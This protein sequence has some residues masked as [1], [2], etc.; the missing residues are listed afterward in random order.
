M[1]GVSVNATA[2]TSPAA[3]EISRPERRP[4]DRHMA[5]RTDPTSF[6]CA[7]RIVRLYQLQGLI[8]INAILPIIDL[9]IADIQFSQ[10][11]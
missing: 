4:W 10:A 9:L 3:S 1:T 2:R 8:L 5:Y 11:Y 6:L 7:E